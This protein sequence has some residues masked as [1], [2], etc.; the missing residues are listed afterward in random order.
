[1]TFITKVYFYHICLKVKGKVVPV[2][3]FK[4]YTIKIYG[5]VAVE[6]QYSLPRY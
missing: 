5:G 4:H 2:L 3:D 1:M 6:L